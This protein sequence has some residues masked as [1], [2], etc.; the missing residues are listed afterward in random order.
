[1]IT[2]ITNGCFDVLHA[3]HVAFLKDAH[4]LGDWLIVGLND[5]ASVR[6]LKGEGRPLQTVEM[7]RLV[8]RELKCVDE[9]IVVHDTDMSGFITM[10]QPTI[11]VKGGDYTLDTLDKREVATANAMHCAIKII[12]VRYKV[13]TSQFLC[14]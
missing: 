12:P 2:V 5:D 1:M 4:K 3:G 7:R 10:T 14:K 13:H 11:W 6:K 8:L 9:V